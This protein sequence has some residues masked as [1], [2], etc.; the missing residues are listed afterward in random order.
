MVVG[1]CIGLLQRRWRD[2]AVFVVVASLIALPQMWWSTHHSAVDATKFFEW[3]FG[4]DRGKDSALWFWFKN[5]GLFIPLVVAA[6]LWRGKGHLVSKRLLL[7]YLPFTLCFIIPNVLK[8]APWIWDNIKVLFYW[9][10]ASAPLVALLLARLWRQGKAQRVL[11]VILF[12]C[13]TLAGA[14]DVAGI[15]LRSV[16][17]Q[18]FD[19]RGIQ[20]AEVVKQETAPQ[21]LIVHAPVHT[22]PVFLTGRRSLLGYPGHIWTHGLDFAER[23]SEIRRIYSGAPDARSLID[24]YRIQYAV[25]GPHERNVLKVNEQFF[26]QFT[27]IG[28][29]GEYRLF[30]V[31]P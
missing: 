21:A 15:A 1:A 5:T 13:V 12:F 10:L 19:P 26:S 17:Y 2:W 11:A 29:V 7:F 18:V 4:W 23:E 30:K 8:M 28:E 16:K 27:E 6:I 24:K 14:L 22:H 25:V 20:F 9:W 31:T 3:Q